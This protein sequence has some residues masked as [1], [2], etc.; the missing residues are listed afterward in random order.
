MENEN[1]WKFSAL[2]TTQANQIQ[3][4]TNSMNKQKSYNAMQRII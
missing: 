4:H 2:L 1:F 3:F